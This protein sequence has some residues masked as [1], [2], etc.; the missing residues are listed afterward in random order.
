M[1]LKLLRGHFYADETAD[2]VQYT[3]KEKASIASYILNN[4]DYR[5][6][7][8]EKYF[9]VCACNLEDVN[10]PVFKNKPI[11]LLDPFG[12]FTIEGFKLLITVAKTIENVRQ[13]RTL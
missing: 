8:Q 6:L 5:K 4:E 3:S 13:L 9:R 10:A 11:T 2:L 7:K 12:F 1:K